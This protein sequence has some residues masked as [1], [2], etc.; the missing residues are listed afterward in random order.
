MTGASSGIG[1]STCQVLTKKGAKVVGT[2]RNEESLS[3]LKQGGEIVDYVVADITKEGECERMVK[4]AAEILGGLTT[5]VNAAGVLYGGAMGEIDLT[6]YRLNM[7]C[8]T[9][10][11]FE[12]MV[13]A[14]P[15][16][17]EPQQT[18]SNCGCTS[19]SIVNVSS[20]NGKQSFASCTSIRQNMESV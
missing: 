5:V 19:R 2:A 12:I 13:H 9:Q 14:I 1:K 8:N 3:A 20:V 11:P 17:K 18:S 4:E 15:Y 7:N 6:N 10:A 16:L